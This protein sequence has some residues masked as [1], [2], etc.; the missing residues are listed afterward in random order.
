MLKRKIELPPEHLY[1]ADEWRIVEARYSEE[2][3][4]LTETVFSLGNGFV[5]VRGSCEEGRPALVPGTFINGFHETW[6]ITHAEGAHALAR[7]GQTIVNVP[8]T[9]ILKLYVDDEPFFLPAARIQDY[10]RIL[11]MRAGTLT[12]E[13]VWATGGGKHVR[14]RSRRI[15]SLEHRHLVAMTYEVTMLDEPAPVVI[16]SLVLNRQDAHLTGDLPEH[17]PGDPRL[18]T[19][20]PHRVLNVRGT[21][22]AD[23]RILI[24]YQTTNSGMTLGIGVDHVIETACPFQVVGSLDDDKTGEV[25]LTADAEPGVPIRV[26]KYATYQT[27]RSI[28]VPELVNRCRRTL[29]R[30]VR[31][32]LDTLLET[33]RAHLARFWDR[34]D[35]QVRTRLNP[36]RQQQAVRWNLYQVAQG[37]WRAEGTGVPAKGLTGQA[38]EG[39]YFWDTEI[40]VLPFLSYTEPR[41]ARNLLRFRHSM[42]PRARERAAE[43]SQRGALFPWR[44]INGE[45]ASSNF[46]QGTAQ[47]HI[48][49]DIAYAIRRYAQVEGSGRVLGEIGAQILVETARLWADLGF[50]GADKRFHIHGVTG[51][52]EYTTV[53]N[54]NAYTNLMARLNLNF[55]AAT[56]RHLREERPGDYTTLVHAVRLQFKEVESWERAAAAMY[57]PFDEE[58]GIHPQD[59]TFL[60]RKAWDL[61]A[62]P[63]EK[64]PLLLHYHPLVIYRQQVLKQAD[65]VLAMFLLGNEFSEEQKRRNFDYYDPLTTGDSSLSACVQSIIAAEIGRERQALEYFQYA[66]LMDL[67]NVAGNASDGV[68]IASAAGVWSSLVFGFGGVRDYDGRLS[69]TPRLPHAWNQL[70]FS[71][72]FCGRQIRVRLTHDEESYL[73]DEGGPLEVIIRGEPHLLSPGTAVAIKLPPP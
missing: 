39:H 30:A 41:I 64:F 6:P 20:L 44:T 57:I 54:D 11:D 8:D 14:V 38:Y 26:T 45:E 28:P 46:Q 71:L 31:N 34:A 65:I 25:L 47:Y 69:F 50:Y 18:A 13:L 55:A 52:D 63:R 15:V 40:Y 19:M 2:F 60:D 42:L 7:T 1:P 24:G 56:V 12:R 35:V 16:S 17:R 70:A 36:V 10:G 21:E 5:G 58:R 62:T 22:L 59:E 73:I 3:V 23:Q 33:Q 53:V 48:N 37:T 9:T 67:G 68:H 61:D 32:G 29:D 72:R 49:A 4:G 66:L 27:S 43:M 51:P